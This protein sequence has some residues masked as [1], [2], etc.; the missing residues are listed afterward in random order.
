M[1]AV[2]PIF[3]VLLSWGSACRDTI[4]TDLATESSSD[5]T[6]LETTAD[7]A[8]S[9]TADEPSTSAPTTAETTSASACGDGELQADEGCDDGINDG[10][11]GGCLPDCSAPAGHCGDGLVQPEGDDGCD[12]G[13]HNGATS[14]NTWCRISGTKLA[15]VSPPTPTWLGDAGDVLATD[16]GQIFVSTY[17][18][19]E[20]WAVRDLGPELSSEHLLVHPPLWRA[21]VLDPST[22]EELSSQQDPTLDRPNTV[23]LRPNGQLVVFAQSPETPWPQLVVGY[24]LDEDGSLHRGASQMLDLGNGNTFVTS[25]VSGPDVNLLVGAVDDNAFVLAVEDLLGEQQSVVWQHIGVQIGFDAKEAAYGAAYRDGRFYVSLGSE[26][27]LATF[28]R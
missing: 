17:N 18:G 1:A 4:P 7:L 2:S 26:A 21:S 27:A 5:S 23:C 25:C 14:C 15:E 6:G 10:A 8:M 11:Y 13:E 9:S 22:G 12:D 16:G 28:A 24:D 20:L 3:L 19:R